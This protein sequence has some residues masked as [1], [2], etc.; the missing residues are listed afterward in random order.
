MDWTACTVHYCTCT[1]EKGVEQFRSAIMA[2]N[3]YG[4]RDIL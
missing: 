1:S 4:F 3:I 2:S